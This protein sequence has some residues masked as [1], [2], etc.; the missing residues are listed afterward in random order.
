VFTVELAEQVHDSYCPWTRWLED[1]ALGARLEH[2][3]YEWDD[4]EEL[5]LSFVVGFDDEGLH[6]QVQHQDGDVAGQGHQ[7]QPV[8]QIFQKRTVTEVCDTFV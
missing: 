2:F 5:L 4:V 8:A 1:F 3:G 6:V 7:A